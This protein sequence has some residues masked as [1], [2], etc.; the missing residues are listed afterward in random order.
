MRKPTTEGEVTTNEIRQLANLLGTPTTNR[1]RS[2]LR[3]SAN[4]RL[5]LGTG[6]SHRT[7]SLRSAGPRSPSAEA[8]SRST[9][10]RMH[11]LMNPL[12]AKN[13]RVVDSPQ[14][15]EP[16]IHPDS[17][18]M[19]SGRYKWWNAASGR[20][21]VDAHIRKRVRRP[22]STISNCSGLNPLGQLAGGSSRNRHP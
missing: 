11:R 21:S 10:S 5:E 17:T 6:V 16:L 13:L 2:M 14:R 4:R 12:V 15:V 22:R 19:I 20:V 3:G 7:I 1:L 18:L 8:I 9:L